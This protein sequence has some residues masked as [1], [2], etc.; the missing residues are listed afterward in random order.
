VLVENIRNAYSQRLSRLPWLQPETKVQALR[1][2]HSTRAKI[3]YPSKWKS[4][5]EI[6]INRNSYF[7]SVRNI[8][9]SAYM[10]KMRD[11]RS[12]VDQEEWPVPPQLVNAFYVSRMTAGFNPFR[13]PSF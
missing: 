8:F 12:S 4:Y 10:K 6:E 13:P 9:R 5:K 3:G 11:L 7:Q 2:L 1:K